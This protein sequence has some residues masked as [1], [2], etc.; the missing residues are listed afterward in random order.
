MRLRH[1]PHVAARGDAVHR[2]VDRGRPHRRGRQAEQVAIALGDQLGGELGDAVQPAWHHV[3]VLGQRLARA[4]RTVMLVDRAGA[5]I[6]EALEVRQR[7]RPVEHRHG[8]HHVDVD[9]AGGIVRL[10]LAPRSGRGAARDRRDGGA[11]D[12][13]RDGMAPPARPASSSGCV[14]SATTTERRARERGE[15]A[16]GGGV[17]RCGIECH[18][19]RVRVGLEPVPG[20]HA[21]DETRRTRH[22]Q[23]HAA[24]PPADS[25]GKVREQTEQGARAD[26][27]IIHRHAP[28]PDCDCRDRCGRISCRTGCRPWR[29]RPHRV[30]RRSPSRRAG[31]AG[32]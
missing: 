14:T 3:A 2:P 22:Q 20:E 27:E 17:E 15:V 21:H 5:D 1:V 10:R 18:E 9:D 8:A 29:T 7:A 11:V 12:D 13:V 32:A 23:R 16:L 28:R 19:A 31:R 4:V 25:D 26:R 24:P 30:P 6:D